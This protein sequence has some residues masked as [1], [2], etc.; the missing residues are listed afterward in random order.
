MVVGGAGVLTVRLLGADVTVNCT[1]R[2]YINQQDMT[3][4]H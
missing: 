2:L 4:P 3:M 1:W